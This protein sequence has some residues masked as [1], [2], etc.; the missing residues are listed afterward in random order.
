MEAWLE[1]VPMQE[2][3]AGEELESGCQLGIGKAQRRRGML[4]VWMGRG[5]GK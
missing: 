3:G 4:C 1:V 2:G 5:A